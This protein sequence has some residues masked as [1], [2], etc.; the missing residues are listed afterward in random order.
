MPTHREADNES[1]EPVG[2]QDLDITVPGIIAQGTFGHECQGG[3]N[4]EES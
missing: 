1:S 4:A 2:S 3:L